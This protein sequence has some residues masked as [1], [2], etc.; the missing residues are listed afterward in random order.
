MSIIIYGYRRR[1]F[2]MFKKKR[3]LKV[4]L[5]IVFYWLMRY[6]YIQYKDVLQELENNIGY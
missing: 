3:K 4:D 5:V 1:D 6:M 2:K